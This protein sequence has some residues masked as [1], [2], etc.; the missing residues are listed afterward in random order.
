MSAPKSLVFPENRR[1]LCLANLS[2]T[3]GRENC[4]DL[5]HRC[6]GVTLASGTASMQDFAASMPATR[7]SLPPLDPASPSLLPAK[8]SVRGWSWVRENRWFRGS[9]VHPQAR[10]PQQNWLGA[11]G[12]MSHV[13]PQ[14]HQF[15]P[16]A[17]TK[18]PNFI[19][20]RTQ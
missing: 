18:T 14:G 15:H 5:R 11:V 10:V 20:L 12:A 17:F 7:C 2:R 9:R 3:V 19:D 8:C 4:V 16:H 6:F 13:W 1:V